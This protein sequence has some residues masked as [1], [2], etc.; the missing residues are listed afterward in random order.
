VPWPEPIAEEAY[1][2]LLGDAVRLVTPTTEADPAALFAHFTVGIGVLLGRETRAMVGNAP[3][4]PKQNA[5]VVGNTSQGRKGT[6][7]RASEG[8]I[9]LA[10][11]TFRL[12]MVEGLS[13]GEGLIWQVRDEIRKFERSK[14]G[15]PPQEVI[16]DPRVDDKRLLVIESEF[17]SV[18]RVAQREGNTL[19]AIV[20]RA[21][22][23]DDLQTL[24]KNNP[25]T[26]TGAHIGIVGHVSRE[27]F[28]RYLDRS[29]LANGFAN[30]FGFYAARRSRL[31]P[32]GDTIPETAL[33]PLA[34]R[35]RVAQEWAAHPRIL[36]RDNQARAIWHDV[37][38]ALTAERA[39][40]FGGAT[41]RAEA[42]VLR[43]SVLYAI[44]DCSASIRA[45]HLLAA[46]AIWRYCE[47]SARW[48]FGD[49]T[50]DPTADT[51]L[52]ALRRNGELDRE[53]IVNLFGR[54]ANRPRIER[55]LSLLLAAGLAH[56]VRQ[57]TGGRP[58][59]VWRA[60]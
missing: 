45:E 55:A 23:R 4:P 6:A 28:L 50:G 37:Y 52:G 59:E 17:A 3:H 10:D 57:P 29:E 34:A 39:G 1:H 36:R 20:R 11:P 43:L 24:T 41:T 2:G 18:L 22:D 33:A 7:Q 58:R 26:A 15:G 8:L 32:E 53:D 40:M 30:R 56:P 35:L 12:R 47:Q 16:V 27:E 31:L 5:V 46:L 54:H 14:D 21:W 51:I 44:L 49:A 25:A 13:S 60:T 9:V 38:G 48:V 19:T 42:Q